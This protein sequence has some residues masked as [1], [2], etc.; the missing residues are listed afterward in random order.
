MRTLWVILGLAIS[1]PVV[2]QEGGQAPPAVASTTAQ[3]SGVQ[4]IAWLA[5]CWQADTAA[6]SVEE[7]WLPPRGGSMVGMSRTVSGNKLVAYE[8]VVVRE[9]GD[10]LSY[11]AH[12][13]GQAS[14]VFT[15]TS[16]SGEKVVFENLEH[17]FP[18]RVGYERR[19]SDLLAWIEG[20]QKGRRRRVEFP[21]RRAACAG[22]RAASR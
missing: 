21:Y 15:S 22:D 6:R 20:D 4:R 1:L 3:A 12:P 9:D 8:L 16:L 7:Q 11:Q 13:S 19:G 17:D 14:A 18:Q 10:R 2:E 5:G